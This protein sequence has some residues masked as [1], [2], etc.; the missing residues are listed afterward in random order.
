MENEVLYNVPVTFNSARKYT[1]LEYKNNRLTFN[2]NNV[3]NNNPITFGYNEVVID[4]HGHYKVTYEEKHP[5]KFEHISNAFHVLFG[6]RPVPT[7]RQTKH[8][9]KRIEAIDEI[10]K[11][12]FIHFNTFKTDIITY[13]KEKDGT[14]TEINLGEHLILEM[15]Q[16][17][18]YKAS[19]KKNISTWS[20][21]TNT[22]YTGNVSWGHFKRYSIDNPV[23]YQRIIDTFQKEAE[24]LFGFTDIENDVLL[25]VLLE[26]FNEKAD[27]ETKNNLTDV[28]H[29]SLLTQYIN[30]IID[31][32]KQGIQGSGIEQIEAKRK[33]SKT[34]HMCYPNLRSIYYVMNVSGKIHMI[35]N[36]RELNDLK[37]G[38]LNATIL[39]GGLLQVDLNN[40]TP[41]DNED[42][43]NEI[44]EYF[45]EYNFISGN[46]LERLTDLIKK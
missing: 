9:L 42:E 21:Y 41:I 36:E 43:M 1:S 8:N 34:L 28:L 35:L 12:S 37:N 33:N 15:I 45:N 24:K 14:Y 27:Q 2:K 30:I 39:D 17:K 3:I 31:N 44:L 18:K 11:K 7:I 32:K 22:I 10:A 23:E 20:P 46:E 13:K 40:I 4:D 6:H 19:N 29:G 5:I 38:P 16:G 25:I 26:M